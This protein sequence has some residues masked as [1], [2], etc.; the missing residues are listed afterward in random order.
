MKAVSTNWAKE[1]ESRRGFI[2]TLFLLIIV[3]ILAV[4]SLRDSYSFDA[5]WHLKMGQDWVEKGLSPFQDHYS[6]VFFGADIK[7]IP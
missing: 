2:L 7:S 1:L 5:F 6:I 4:S 3:F